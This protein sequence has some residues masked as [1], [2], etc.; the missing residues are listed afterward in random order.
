MYALDCA[1]LM[2]VV[3]KKYTS[4]VSEKAMHVCM[5][6]DGILGSVT[7]YPPVKWFTSHMEKD[8]H[9]KG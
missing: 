3:E 5:V 9:G 7:I 6:V 8:H 4:P 2:T 1:L